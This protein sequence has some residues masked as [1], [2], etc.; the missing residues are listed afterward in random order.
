MVVTGR[1][2]GAEEAQRWGVLREIVPL[3]QLMDIA[4]GLAELIATGPPL[5]FT[6]IKETLRETEDLPI[7]AAFDLVNSGRL[8]TVKTLYE[9]EDTIEGARAFAEKRDP[10]WRGR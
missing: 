1:W 10:V 7:Q 9:S 6:A 8:K 4:R 2:M 3:S 5:L